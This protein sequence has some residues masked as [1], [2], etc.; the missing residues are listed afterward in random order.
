MAIRKGDY[1]LVRPSLGKKE[2][3][4]IAKTPM[5]F[6]LAKDISQEKDLAALQP[7]LVRELQADWERWNAELADPRWPATFQG[8]PL[9][10]P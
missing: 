2:Y 1:V 5:L 6:N 9:K 10:M 7:D 4:N 3:E 8:K